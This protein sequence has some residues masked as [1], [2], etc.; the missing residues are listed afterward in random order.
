VHEVL[1]DKLQYRKVFGWLQGRIKCFVVVSHAVAHSLKRIGIDPARIH[2]IHN[3]IDDPSGDKTPPRCQSAPFRIGIVGQ[4]GEWKGHDDLVEALHLLRQK[5]QRFELHIFGRGATQY[6]TQLSGKILAL[7]LTK[8]VFLHGFSS[9]RTQIYE[10][11][12]VCVVPSRSDDPL[13]TTAIEA[14]FFQ[15]PVIATRRGGLPEIIEDGVTG[16]LVDAANPLQIAYRL[17]ELMNDESLRFRL[18]RQAR[19]RMINKFGRKQ[20]VEEFALLLHENKCQ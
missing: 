5:H 6:E 7:D 10:C 14:G 8:H 18:G 12:D 15:K 19:S 20:F 9:D 16:F 1:P 3:G 2:V 13:P 4:I 17:E 11:L